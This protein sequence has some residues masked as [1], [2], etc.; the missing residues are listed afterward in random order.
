MRAW[1]QWGL[2]SSDALFSFLMYRATERAL[3]MGHTPSPWNTAKRKMGKGAKR[4]MCTKCGRALFALPYGQHGIV[5][6]IAR[7]APTVTGE[8]LSFRCS[9]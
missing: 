9:A 4:A 8:A 1:K 6:K 7:D 2:L 3:D 5:P